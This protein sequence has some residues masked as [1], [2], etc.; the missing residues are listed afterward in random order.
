MAA[1][2][3][4]DAI[5]L[6]L[7]TDTY[8]PQLNGVSRTLDR[9]V[10]AV[11]ARGGAVR[12]YTTTDPGVDPQASSGANI[13][14]RPSLPFWAYPQL[15]IAAPVLGRAYPDIRRWRP[16]LIHAATPFGMGLAGRSCARA[17]GVPLVTSYHT[18]FNEYAKFYRLGALSAPGWAYIRWF[19]N[20]GARTYAP[21]RAV[22]DELRARGFQRLAIWGR[23]V[24]TRAFHAA[25]RDPAWRAR[26]GADEQTVVVAY[27]GRLAAE[28]GL[29]T[30]LGAMHVLADR[31]PG[32][33][34]RR[35]GARSETGGAGGTR[36]V[37]A[38]AGDGPY[39]A[40]CRRTAPPA[41]HFVGRLEGAALSAFY[42]SAD[43]FIFPSSTD[44][45]GNVLLEAMASGLAVI[46][47][48]SGPTREIL[49]SGGGVV[50]PRGDANALAQAIVALAENR[51]RRAELGA[52]GVSYAASCSWNR[53]FDDLVED[54]RA[55]MRSG[56]VAMR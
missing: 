41:V 3:A 14:R 6:A 33:V 43:V 31:A 10:R 8:S 29:D 17:L 16:T 56:R 25:F 23:G 24:E 30:A 7:F 40:H 21:T 27:V 47:A 36:I 19:H 54:Y 44:T 48:D 50:V 35:C 18:S 20:S 46:G 15:R 49:A 5:R 28:K 38:L 26:F 55:V 32:T 9:L 34:G 4:P 11:A 12:V 1:V 52:R 13:W 53:V 2:H 39:A 45:F 37:F 42:A 22:L 51:A